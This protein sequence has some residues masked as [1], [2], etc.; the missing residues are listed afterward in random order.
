MGFY[1]IVLLLGLFVSLFTIC[2]IL[3][4]ITVLNA[5]FQGWGSTIDSGPLFSWAE[6]VAYGGL[7]FNWDEDVAYG[8]LIEETPRDDQP[9][10]HTLAVVFIEIY[11]I[12]ECLEFDKMLIPKCKVLRDLAMKKM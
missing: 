6:D 12:I 11:R 5:F 8:L 10:N 7:L 2:V 3:K 9:N 4:R 1:I